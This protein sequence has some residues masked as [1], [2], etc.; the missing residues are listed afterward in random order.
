VFGDIPL[1]DEPQ[2]Q[3]EIVKVKM[4]EKGYNIESWPN[5]L[6]FPPQVL[7][8]R[9]FEDLVV[10]L[11]HRNQSVLSLVR[12]KLMQ[13]YALVGDWPAFLQSLSRDIEG[14][15]SAKLKVTDEATDRFVNE[16]FGGEARQGPEKKTTP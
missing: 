6:E 5:P 9:T 4:S 10:T 13:P 3:E 1:V 14:L 2:F 7:P 8:I 11:K 12:E 15:D 16:M